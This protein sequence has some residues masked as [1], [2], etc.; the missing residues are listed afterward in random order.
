MV[1]HVGIDSTHR[2]LMS[3]RRFSSF[4]VSAMICG[5]I[6]RPNLSCSQQQRSELS[7]GTQTPLR[8]NRIVE[9]RQSAS[10]RQAVCSRRC[11]TAGTFVQRW[12]VDQEGRVPSTPI[13]RNPFLPEPS[14]NILS[15]TSRN[16]EKSAEFSELFWIVLDPSRS[17]FCTM[18]LAQ[19]AH[20]YMCRL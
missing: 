3:R 12:S 19:R 18:V 6:C 2:S 9:A 11:S 16:L 17:F 10:A 1:R 13:Y 4:C 5:S 7:A 8:H 15:K 20:W 14:S